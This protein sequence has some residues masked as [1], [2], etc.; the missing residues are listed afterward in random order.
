MPV[1]TPGTEAA[2]GSST[3]RDPSQRRDADREPD[4]ASDE[5]SRE[6]EHALEQTGRRL[7][8]PTLEQIRCNYL[9][10]FSSSFSGAVRSC[11]ALSHWADR[12]LRLRLLAKDRPSNE[13]SNMVLCRLRP[14][15][16]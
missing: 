15:T 14:R 1:Q 7:F 9:L 3:R 5:M 2:P 11:V 10:S 13:Q 8:L 4:H 6:P 12:V 16:C